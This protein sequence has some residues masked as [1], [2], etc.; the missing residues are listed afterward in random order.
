MKIDSLFISWVN[1]PINDISRQHS[2]DEWL[3]GWI[4]IHATEF[5]QGFKA[6]S[7][8]T[9][10]KRGSKWKIIHFLTASILTE[11]LRKK[12]GSGILDISIHW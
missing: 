8:T 9:N 1:G 3:L 11:W 12:I 5:L 6:Y 4:R 2:S 10:D 7:F